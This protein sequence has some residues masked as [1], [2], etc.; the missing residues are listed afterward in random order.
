M[1]FRTEYLTFNTSSRREYIDITS[2]MEKAL[3][4][5]GIKEG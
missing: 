4:Q 3:A 1:K 2:S 5:S